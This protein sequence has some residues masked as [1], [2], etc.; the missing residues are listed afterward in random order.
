MNR[1]NAAILHGAV[2]LT[3]TFCASSSKVDMKEPARLLGRENDVRID[4]QVT[5]NELNDLI[6]HNSVVPF[7]YE[8]HNFRPTAIA[9]S[10]VVAE[11]TFDEDS[12]I[13]T[14]ALGS[15]VPGNEFV[16]R[17]VAI[18]SGESRTFTASARMSGFLVAPR[19]DLTVWPE[20]IRL[21]VNY[22]KDVQPFQRLIGIPETGIR[23]PKLAE[24]LFTAWTDNIEVV[25]TN[26]V[27]VA[28]RGR[29]R[30]PQSNMLHP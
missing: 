21:K 12:R 7:T 22:L 9:V 20:A 14:V 5:S 13:I 24:A 18:A 26:A 23:D 8:I 27:P 11:T 3:L 25:Y 15:E 6:G 19:G 28:W 29:P 30:S 1:R 2:M 17:L 10:D 4:A 16:P